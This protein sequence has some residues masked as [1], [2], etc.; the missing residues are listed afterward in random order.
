M[1]T[2][3]CSA[4]VAALLLANI[5]ASHLRAADK[6]CKAQT[7]PAGR[8][9]F[10]LD[11]ALATAA[12]QGGPI[13]PMVKQALNDW[14]L[15][16]GREVTFVECRMYVQLPSGVKTKATSDLIA[17]CPDGEK[18]RAFV[19]FR[20]GLS[21]NPEGCST[22]G[23]GSLGIPSSVYLGKKCDLRSIRH[24]IG[25][26]LGLYHEQARPDRAGI[27][28]VNSSNLTPTGEYQFRLRES[29]CFR[30]PYDVRSLMHYPR[31]TGSK[32]FVKIV[33]QPMWNPASPLPFAS[34]PADKVGTGS[35]ISATDVEEVRL[36]YGWNGVS[37]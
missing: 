17:F 37:P 29:S 27:I 21:E 13:L 33:N 24:E 5:Q 22:E 8:V 19:I 15:L 31:F 11:D 1:K 30:G 6:V 3:T 16:V 4:L 10:V 35:L 12:G 32:A 25:H 14:Q 28:S 23:P 20:P 36:L 34:F 2:R 9:P 18:E 7:W 26:V